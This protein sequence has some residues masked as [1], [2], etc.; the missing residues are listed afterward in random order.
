MNCSTVQKCIPDLWISDMD[1]KRRI[2]VETH[3][4]GCNICSRWYSIWKNLRV[5]G[6]EQIRL[7]QML[8]W[9]PFNYALEIELQRNPRPG[10]QLS[11]VKQIQAGFGGFLRIL[12]RKHSA[13]PAA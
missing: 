9:K 4:I 13:Q 10:R 6:Q 8:N 12:T 1:F 2:D 5:I 3:L 11:G 7:P